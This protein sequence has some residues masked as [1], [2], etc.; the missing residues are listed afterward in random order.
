ME[1]RARIVALA[2]R[3]V[4]ARFPDG[5]AGELVVVVA[6]RRPGQGLSCE[7]RLMVRGR[8]VLSLRSRTLD[9]L[10][11]LGVLTRSGGGPGVVVYDLSVPTLDRLEGAG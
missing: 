10:E 7:S 3:L 6:R 2:R 11:R 5:D 9:A 8:H 4:D 1:R